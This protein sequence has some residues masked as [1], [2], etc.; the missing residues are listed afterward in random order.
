MRL[1]QPGG[2]RQRGGDWWWLAGQTWHDLLL[3]GG[4][5]IIAKQA[6]GAWPSLARPIILVRF[7]NSAITYRDIF[8]K[9]LASP[10]SPYPDPSLPLLDDLRP[11][12]DLTSPTVRSY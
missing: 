2:D 7:P 9:P 3:R 12:A 5:L 8:D 10:A 4:E 11:A 1:F 6:E